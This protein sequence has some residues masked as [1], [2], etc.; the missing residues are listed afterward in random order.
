V[1]LYRCEQ[2]GW[3]TTAFRFE[4]VPAHRTDCPECAGVL[5]MTFDAMAPRSGGTGI[6]RLA[7]HGDLSQAPHVVSER[8]LT[9]TRAVVDPS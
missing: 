6:R 8:P 5:R 3:A 2:C 4:A 9:P 7:G 1:P